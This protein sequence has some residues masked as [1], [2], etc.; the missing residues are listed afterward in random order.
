MHAHTNYAQKE[1]LAFEKATLWTFHW[2]GI[3]SHGQMICSPVVFPLEFLLLS[4]FMSSKLFL[5][6]YKTHAFEFSRTSRRLAHRLMQSDISEN[7][8]GRDR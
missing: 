3:N 4:D 6:E 7:F 8:P 5:R 2:L 1:F